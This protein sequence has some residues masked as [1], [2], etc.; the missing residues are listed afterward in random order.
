ML[1]ETNVEGCWNDEEEL[2]SANAL[3]SLKDYGPAKAPQNLN[4]VIPRRVK[5]KNKARLS[6]IK[7]GA[8]RMTKIAKVTLEKL[9]S[10]MRKTIV[11]AA[12]ELNVAVTY[13][14]HICRY[15]GIS[16]WP[17]R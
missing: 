15:H 1:S 11:Q 6:K 16:A 7:N 3:L 9:Q 17:S 12:S 8:G 2:K 5:L 10:L 13:F 14:K 4:V